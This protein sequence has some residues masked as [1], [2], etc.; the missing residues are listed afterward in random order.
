V[1]SHPRTALL[2]PEEY[3]EA[4]RRAEIKH[5]Y[6]GGEIVALAGASE[7]HNL[8]VANLIVA[9]GAQLR[10]SPCRAYPSD[11]RVRTRPDH[12]LYPDVTVVCGESRLAD[13]RR[14]VLLNPTLIVEV[15]SPSTETRDR[16]DKLDQYRKVPTLRDFLL[17]SQDA[18][19]IQ[20]YARREG[21]FWLFSETT[22]AGAVLQLDSIGCTLALDDVYDRVA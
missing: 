8:V 19:R 20:R 5:E 22:E 3:L 16:T 11:L 9:L 17:V 18:R 15:L 21:D 6:W 10:R 4:E 1:S 14:D 7:R 13:E 2:S 12:Y